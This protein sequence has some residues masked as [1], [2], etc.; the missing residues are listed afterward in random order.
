MSVQLA[1]YQPNKP[2]RVYHKMEK[3]EPF[4]VLILEKH[5]AGM[6]QKRLRAIVKNLVGF[7]PGP[8][9]MK[10]ILQEWHAP[11][12]NLTRAR[13]AHIQKVVKERR[14]M[15]K[16]DPRVKFSIKG[17]TKVLIQ[18]EVDEIMKISDLAGVKPD[19]VGM[20]LYTPTPGPSST[21][22]EEQLHPGEPHYTLESP[23]IRNSG[24]YFDTTIVDG[25]TE[26]ILGKAMEMNEDENGME[27]E[28]GFMI[29]NQ[30]DEEDLQLNHHRSEET[31]EELQQII[32]R[33][34]KRVK[35]EDTAG[36]EIDEDLLDSII[37]EV[38]TEY[39][40]SDEDFDDSDNSD[41]S[42]DLVIDW[43]SP[44]LRRYARRYRI[45]YEDFI[46]FWEDIA[47]DM[48]EKVEVYIARGLS[49]EVA[50][51]MASK[52]NEEEHGFH[53][54]YEVCLDILQINGPKEIEIDEDEGR[55]IL[56]YFE[57]LFSYLRANHKDSLKNLFAS[58][59]D[60]FKS[61]VIHLPRFITEY[62]VRSFFVATSILSAFQMLAIY[63]FKFFGDLLSPLADRSIGIFEQIGMG[64]NTF[65][66]DYDYFEL[67]NCQGRDRVLER[68]SHCYGGTGHPILVQRDIFEAL[69]MALKNNPG[70]RKA[71]DQLLSKIGHNIQLCVQ[72]FPQGKGLIDMFLAVWE[73]FDNVSASAAT[74]LRKPLQNC[75]PS[76]ERSHADKKYPSTALAV[77]TISLGMTYA[78]TENFGV[79][80]ELLIKGQGIFA[81]RYAATEFSGS[82]IFLLQ[83]ISNIV[84]AR[85]PVLYLSLQPIFVDYHKYLSKSQRLRS[86]WE[87]LEWQKLLK[88]YKTYKNNLLKEDYSKI[89]AHRP[90]SRSSTPDL[91]S[92]HYYASLKD[93]MYS[94]GWEDSTAD[95]HLGGQVMEVDDTGTGIHTT[96]TEISAEEELRMITQ[97]YIQAEAAGLVDANGRFPF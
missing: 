90:R 61:Y 30:S 41:D 36:I 46:E 91:R 54:P 28:E 21:P 59:A 34:L 29:S 19:P 94:Q 4:K 92:Y 22:T 14:E 15:Q 85:G 77:C 35:T 42:D 26:I 47:K 53:L 63:A 7:D 48:V 32:A 24:P 66:W 88:K 6:S 33:Q 44:M 18:E 3:L 39:E 67:R 76:F 81:E 64:D 49:P 60:L 11:K 40:L 75:I 80:L 96:T 89:L 23:H 84:E 17:Q 79:S 58:R 55:D 38:D 95:I 12:V 16:V 78:H 1:Q 87:R 74:K 43:L 71:L 72:N 8:S 25:D 82:M 93:W 9:R 86:L 68:L 45:Y 65:I 56:T 31:I 97:R 51:R 62:G 57:D 13:K 83:D 52:E 2:T 37:E 69:Q 27:C 50:G 5:E 20:Q 10:R 73:L 70:D